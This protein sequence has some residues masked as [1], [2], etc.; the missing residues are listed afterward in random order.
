[1]NADEI[2][3][4]VKVS[5]GHTVYT[6]TSSPTNDIFRAM[7]S[8]GEHTSLSVQEVVKVRPEPSSDSPSA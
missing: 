8:R 1:M 4:G 3:A 6:A 2:Y 7:D 5:K